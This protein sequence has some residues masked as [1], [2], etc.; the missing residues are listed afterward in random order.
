MSEVEGALSHTGDTPLWKGTVIKNYK[1][2]IF[3]FFFLILNF[4]FFFFF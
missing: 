1:F 3:F 2:N 4:Q